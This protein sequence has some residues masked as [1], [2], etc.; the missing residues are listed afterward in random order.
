R[1]CTH[2]RGLGLARGQRHGTH[3]HPE[4]RPIGERNGHA[5]HTEYEVL[6]I[7]W[8]H[9][10]GVSPTEL[11]RMFHDNVWTIMDIVNGCTWKHLLPLQEGWEPDLE[12]LCLF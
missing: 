1:T 8:L 10:R 9:A 12:Q 7:R 4:S 5:A 2:P 6:L 3:T 11:S